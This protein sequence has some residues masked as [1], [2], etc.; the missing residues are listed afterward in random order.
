MLLCALAESKSV[1]A[2]N[3]YQEILCLIMNF[4]GKVSLVGRLPLVA[5]RVNKEGSDEIEQLR[6]MRIQEAILKILKES[7]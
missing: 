5:E 4:R 3:L 1:R 7:G 2:S 6:A